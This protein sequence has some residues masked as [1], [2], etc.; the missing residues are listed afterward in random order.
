ME[1]SREP[2]ASVRSRAT[3]ANAPIRNGEYGACTVRSLRRRFALPLSS[4]SRV[5]S[6]RQ[7]KCLSDTYVLLTCVLVESLLGGT[8]SH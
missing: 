7:P 4:R 3:F 1:P 2:A 5:G 8:S 6:V